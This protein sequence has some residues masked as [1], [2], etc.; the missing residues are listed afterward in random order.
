M[1]SKLIKGVYAAVLTPRAN[2]GSFDRSAFRTLIRFLLDSGIEGFAINGATGE[3]P[4]TQPEELRDQ[5]DEVRTLAGDRAG[6]LCGVGAAS[7]LQ[8]LELAEIARDC[9]VT[10]LLLPAPFYFRYSQADLIAWASTIA[11]ESIL[12]C[13]LYNLPQFATGFDPATTHG[14]IRDHS[15]ILGVK[16]SSGSLDTL[17]LL[18]REQ[19]E[20]CRIVGNDNAL[21]GALLENVCDGVVSG[22]AS[23]LP[24]FILE[25]FHAQ[26]D[27]QAFTRYSALLSEFTRQIDIFPTPWGLKWAAEARGLLSAHF[28]Q[29]LAPDRQ[30]AASK[31]QAWLMDWL[32]QATPAAQ[33]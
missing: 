26:R 31:M 12:P 11:T 1:D 4:L 16:D 8:S 23:V 19:P 20:A 9:A 18:S 30:Q 14:L 21:A 10:A 25:L 3:F 28:A 5:L 2:D 32:P 33:R 22:V 24:E 15:S 17:R 13:L 27:S 29:S 7:I 6:V